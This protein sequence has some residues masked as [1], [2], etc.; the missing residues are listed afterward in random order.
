MVPGT[1]TLPATASA[2]NAFTFSA[3]P[4]NTARSGVSKSFA[5]QG[6]QVLDVYEYLINGNGSNNIVLRIRM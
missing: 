6:F 3:V 4:T 5:K 2:F 1:Y